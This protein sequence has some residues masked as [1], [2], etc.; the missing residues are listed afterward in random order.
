MSKREGW[1]NN[2]L[3]P[4]SQ[5]HQRQSESVNDAE[6]SPFQRRKAQTVWDIFCFQ[7]NRLKTTQI[8]TL[9][10]RQVPHYRLKST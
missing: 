1:L 7:N 10:H 5:E 6:T 2:T 8:Y 9:L 3:I 4:S